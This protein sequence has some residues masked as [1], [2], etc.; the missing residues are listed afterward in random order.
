VNYAAVSHTAG[1]SRTWLYRQDE[2]RDLISELRDHEPSAAA[3][4]ATSVNDL[5]AGPPRRPGC[6]AS[7]WASRAACS[8]RARARSGALCLGAPP[9]GPSSKQLHGWPACIF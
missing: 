4:H 2:I 7:F 1:V 3:R 8:A 5:G 6:A 9:P